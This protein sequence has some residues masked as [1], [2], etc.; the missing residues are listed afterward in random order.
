MC[1]LLLV[2]EPVVWWV[3]WLDFSLLTCLVLRYPNRLRGRK[4][5]FCGS[6]YNVKLILS[7]SLL[8][9][10]WLDSHFSLY[11]KL[12]T[13]TPPS[14]PICVPLEKNGTVREFCRHVFELHNPKDLSPPPKKRH[15]H[16]HQRI[17]DT[18]VDPYCIGCIGPKKCYDYVTQPTIL[19]SSAR[20]SGEE[21]P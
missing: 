15:H 5:V 20:P 2:F 12:F 11:T 18:Y 7:V 10:F 4:T 17:D 9:A 19:F 8:H 16:P 13:E 6:E 21:D 3:G 14:S 1:P